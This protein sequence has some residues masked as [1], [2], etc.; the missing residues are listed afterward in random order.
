MVVLEKI[1]KFLH[2]K[3]KFDHKP[4]M[5]DVIEKFDEIHSDFKKA[6]QAEN[7]PEI[8]QSTSKYLIELIMISNR[9]D[10]DM[11]ALLSEEFNLN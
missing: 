4:E 9:Y 8:K 5:Y 6:L 7:V 1:Q 3:H 2:N 10:I 11:S